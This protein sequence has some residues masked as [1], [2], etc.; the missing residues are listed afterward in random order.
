MSFLRK[1]QHD[2]GNIWKE[3]LKALE[4]TWETVEVFIWTLGRG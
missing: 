3:F 4:A 2:F 1:I